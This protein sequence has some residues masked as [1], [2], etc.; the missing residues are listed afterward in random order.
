M[1]CRNLSSDVLVKELHQL[2]T[3][4]S[5]DELEVQEHG[6]IS[7]DIHRSLQLPGWQFLIDETTYCAI[8]GIGIILSSRA[9]KA[10]LFSFPSHPIEK[11]VQDVSDRCFNVL[12]V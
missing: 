4:R 7:I 1:Y 3:D 12:C 9:V 2:S 6:H 10:L 11:I 8:G 5:I